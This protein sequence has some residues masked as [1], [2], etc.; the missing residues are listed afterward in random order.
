ML[1]NSQHGEGRMQ[2]KIGGPSQR[3]HGVGGRGGLESDAVVL[4]I[5]CPEVSGLCILLEDWVARKGTLGSYLDISL[6]WK[7]LGFYAMVF[8]C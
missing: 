6:A 5:L 8:S 1:K 2:S 3:F 4:N 7:T